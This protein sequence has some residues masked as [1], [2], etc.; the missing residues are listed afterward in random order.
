LVELLQLRSVFCGGPPHCL[1][2]MQ[3]F[4]DVPWRRWLV[5][6]LFTAVARVQSQASPCGICGRHSDA[7]TGSFLPPS[8]PV[9]PVTIILPMLHTRS[10]IYHRRC[11]MFFFQY[12]S[13]PCQY[14]PTN[15]P[16]SFIHLP[17][18]LCN[19][20]LPVPHFPPVSVIS[21]VLRAYL[22]PTPYNLSSWH[23]TLFVQYCDVLLRHSVS[24]LVSLC[25]SCRSTCLN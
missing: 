4:R 8:T 9:S 25:F 11:I 23:Y 13:F 15:A 6:C 24:T 14:H 12:F 3:Y 17:P 16:C 20:F 22:P 1:T 18:T 10:F 2:L 19:G 5:A 7:A 21:A